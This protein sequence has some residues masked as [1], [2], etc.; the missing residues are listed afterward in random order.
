[1]V[2]AHLVKSGAVVLMPFGNNQRYDF[3]VDLGTG[4]FERI[5]VKTGRLVNGSVR[6]KTSSVNGF[7]GKRTGYDGGADTFY[8]YCPENEQVY[9]VP[10]DECGASNFTLRVDPIPAGKEHLVR[11]WAKDYAA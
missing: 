6:F 2:L 4:A 3:V 11:R 8:V 9:R 10:V 7:T 5:Q 1:M